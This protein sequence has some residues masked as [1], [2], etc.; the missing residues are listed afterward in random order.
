LK[1]EN[2][3]QGDITII[4]IHGNLVGT[5]EADKLHGAVENLIKEGRRKIVLDMSDV[6]WMG[7]LCIGAIMREIISVRRNGGDI[8]LAGLS[9]KVRRI[10]Q[11]TKLDEIIRIFPAIRTAL[12]RF[13]R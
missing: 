8:F 11:I 10:F 2:K 12:E 3:F 6:D 4:T 7:S 5:F 13:E 9:R 1:L